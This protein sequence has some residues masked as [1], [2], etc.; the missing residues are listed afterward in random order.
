MNIVNSTTDL[1]LEKASLIL[2]SVDNLKISYGYEHSFRVYHQEL[3]PNRF[4]LT[5]NKKSIKQNPDETIT[6]ICRCLNMPSNFIAATAENI[7]KA[8]FVHFGFEQ[9]QTTYLYKIYLEMGVHLKGS[10]QKNSDDNTPILLHLGLKWDALNPEKQFITRYLWHQSITVQDILQRLTEIYQ[11]DKYYEVFSI[12]KNILEIA[13]NQA[14]D[15]CVNYLEV[16]EDNNQRKSYDLNIY[17]AQLQIKD[18]HHIFMRICSHYSISEDLFIDFYNRIQNKIFGHIAG[19]IHRNS[20]DF[21]N[22]YYGV[23]GRN[24]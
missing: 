4:L 17:N 1:G 3:L 13:V 6:K 2:Q 16:T 9:N 23:E 11:G 18:L 14:G 8:K 10:N 24:G 12:V 7:T 5:I 19:G 20:L 15:D 21:L 22:V